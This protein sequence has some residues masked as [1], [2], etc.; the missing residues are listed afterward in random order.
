MI[1]EILLA[2]AGAMGY[3]MLFGMK[4]KDISLIG[5]NSAFA[6]YLY[7]QI[8]EGTDNTIF[9]MFFVTVLVGLVSGILTIFRKC[10]LT[11]FATPILMPFVPGSTLYYVMYDIVNKREQLWI[12]VLWLFQ[13]VGAIT[14]GILAAEIVLTW[15]RL[16]YSRFPKRRWR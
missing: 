8:A 12:D 16:C 14:F 11:V 10:P 4:G 13:Q 6:W 5:I 7:L 15:I 9:A 3:A 1:K 2:A